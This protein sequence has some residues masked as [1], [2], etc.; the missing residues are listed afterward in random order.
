MMNG[1]LKLRVAD[2]GCL[3]GVDNLLQR[4][5][6][7]L[8]ILLGTDCC[9]CIEPSVPA[10]TIAS[11]LHM[12]SVLNKRPEGKMVHQHYQPAVVTN[13]Y[14]GEQVTF[15]FLAPLYCVLY[16]V[17]LAILHSFQEFG[18]LQKLC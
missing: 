6:L 5:F 1:A 8:K 10:E 16:V 17:C 18:F 9:Q 4:W 11:T 15:V 14:S 2:I 12:I 7:L 13:R 3:E